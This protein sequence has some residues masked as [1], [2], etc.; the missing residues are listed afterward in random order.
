MSSTDSTRERALGA[1]VGTAAAAIAEML[2]EKRFLLSEDELASVA[3]KDD[4]LAGWVF[5]YRVSQVNGEAQRSLLL[6]G[7]R[8]SNPRVREQACDLIGDGR[9]VA[10]RNELRPLFEDR[11]I[12]VAE[13]A[14]YNY[15]MLAV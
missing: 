8:S 1:R 4:L 7:L 15:E 2:R 5:A 11:D 9:M 3:S 10:L 13:A 6:Q 12:G 14:R